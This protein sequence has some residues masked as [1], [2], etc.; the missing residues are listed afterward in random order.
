MKKAFHETT[1]SKVEAGDTVLFAWP[2]RRRLRVPKI[3][4]V[5]VERCE[6]ATANDKRVVVARFRRDGLEYGRSFDLDETVY[7]QSR[8]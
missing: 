8:L 7:V 5:E 1:W 6:F 2:E 4:K 3:V